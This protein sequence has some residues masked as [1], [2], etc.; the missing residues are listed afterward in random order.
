MPPG[1]QLEAA[2]IALECFFVSTLGFG[3]CFCGV[4]AA[5]SR[6]ATYSFCGGI[7]VVGSCRTDSSKFA[8]H[9][10]CSQK[11]IVRESFIYPNVNWIVGVL[12]DG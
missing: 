2:A 10:P 4:F 6:S 9:H 8:L 7:D 12:G 5:T 1:D 3:G 11:L